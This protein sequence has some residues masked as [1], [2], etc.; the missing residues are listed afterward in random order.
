M[1]TLKDIADKAHVTVSTVSKALNGNST[2]SEKKRKEIFT[3]AD[4]LGYIPTA[5]NRVFKKTNLIGILVPELQSP[6]FVQL[7]SNLESILIANGYVPLLYV[8]D[9]VS[10]VNPE[11]EEKAFQLFIEKNANGI[12]YIMPSSPSAEQ[13]VSDAAEKYQIHTVMIYTTSSISCSSV[14]IDETAVMKQLLELLLEKGYSRIGFISDM[15]IKNMRYKNFLDTLQLLGGSISE[16]EKYSAFSEHRYAQGGYEAIEKLYMRGCIP[17]ALIS[18]SD[19]FTIGAMRFASERKICIPKDLALASFDNI[20]VAP[21][22]Y[23]SLTTVA[24]PFQEIAEVSF[25]LLSESN[26]RR[27][28]SYVHTVTLQPKLI[29]RESV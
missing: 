8:S 24:H 27:G 6:F 15:P 26:K 29:I 16:A 4:E 18:G 21:Y 10:D 2:I 7:I 3:I 17:D 22:L 5:R 20:T 25:Q 11:Q 9:Y 28:T 1:I 23:P 19:I 13:M 14:I 12:F